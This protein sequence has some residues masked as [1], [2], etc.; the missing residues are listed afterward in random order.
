M[1]KTSQAHFSTS[2]PGWASSSLRQLLASPAVRAGILSAAAISAAQG[3]D[4]TWGITGSGSWATSANWA[5]VGTPSGTDPIAVG[6]TAA[7]TITLDT[8]KA[9]PSLSVTNTGTTAITAASGGPLG[10][11]LGAGGFTVATG[12]GLVTIGST[13]AANNVNVVLGASQTWTSA[14][15]GSHLI[16]GSITGSGMNLTLSGNYDMRS[17]AGGTPLINI[18]TGI[19]TLT[20]GGFEIGTG[21]NT[22]GGFILKGGNV[23]ARNAGN[24]GTTGPITLGDSAANTT[25]VAL[26]LA[27]ATW[28]RPVVLASGT[29]GTMFIDNLG[30]TATPTFT[31]GITGTNNF[32]IQSTIGS[33]S[34]SVTVSTGAIDFTGALTLRNQGTG[35]VATAAGTVTMNSAITD[36]VTNVTMTDVTTGTKGIQKIVLGNAA[37]AWSGTTTVSA[38]TRV[39]LGASE[40]IPHG[41]GKGNVVVNGNLILRTA[42]GDSTETINGLSGSSTGSITR[43]GA[44]GTS[45]LVVGGNDGGGTFAGNITDGSGKV[46]LTKIGTGTLV[47]SGMNTYTGL[48]TLSGGT[49][50]LDFP[51]LI[52]DAGNIVLE[53]GTTLNLT[54]GDV[55]TV[56]SLRFGTEPQARGKWGRIGSIAALGANF[57]SAQI[58]GDGLLD[59]TNTF[60]DSYWDGSGTSWASAASWSISPTNAAS[61]PGA[62]PGINNP[63]FFGSNGLTA[64]QVIA[65]NGDQATTGMSFTSPVAFSFTGGNANHVLTVTTGGISMDAVSTGVTIGSATAGQEVDLLLSGSQTWNNQSTGG[66]LVAS[67]DVDLGGGTLTVTGGGDTFIDGVVGGT[68]GITKTGAGVLGLYGANSFSGAVSLQ[69]GSIQ[70]GNA[71]GLGSTAGGTTVGGGTTLDLNGL[72]VGAEPITLGVSTAGNLVNNNPGAAAS[73]SGDI[74]INANSNAGGAGDLTLSGLISQTAGAK[75]LAKTGVGKLTITNAN[76]YTGTTT[77]ANNTG[78]VAI[79]NAAALGTGTVAITRGGT[80]TGTLELS[81]DITVANVFTFASATGFSAAGSSAQVRN[82][83]GN[84]TLT[85]TLT[86]TAT[87]GNGINLESN[88]GLL[89]VTNTIT[90]TVADSTRQLGLSGT[91]AGLVSGNIIDTG[92]NKFTVIKSGTGTW[93]LSGTNTYSGGTNVNA[94]VLVLTKNGGLADTASVNVATDGVLQLDFAGSDTVGTLILDGV[95]QGP[96]TYGAGNSGG[97]LTGTGTIT[98]VGS[99]PFTPWI[100]SFTF[101][102]GA[103]KSK[104][105]DPDGDGLSNLQE[106]AFDGNPSSGAASG[107]IVTKVDADHLTLT[108]PVRTGAVFTGTGP[109]T[110]AAIGDVIYRIDGSANLSGFTAGVEETTA[111]TAGLPALSSGW[112]YRTFRLTA[113]VSAARKGFL[114]ADASDAP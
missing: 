22:M 53:A 43:T 113:A 99:D 90:S 64:D 17:H 63:T 34:G 30:A 67:N 16:R 112:T 47:L 36:K 55:E 32:M 28:A 66:D 25:P 58:T 13:T 92:V 38:N 114:R 33:G 50:Q 62:E 45:T 31:G 2:S 10:L 71:G 49:L 23:F 103:D 44:S 51:D 101:A 14:I 26:R 89:T 107:K 80:S 105:G 86:L 83:S 48:T 7:T 42:T 4:Y 12:S 79:T 96:G 56:N 69:G 52:A 19:I 60:V 84:N 3:V 111:L 24:F 68:G 11:T 91:A 41:A 59:V 29:T 82:V 75:N 65:L 87:G 95:T 54:H 40:V 102:V 81:N 46:A 37:N 18:G 104:T 20:S 8:A 74:N 76:L 61:N 57:E 5:P 88:G 39:E 109:L 106:F 85:G 77:I 15:G 6:G 70:L 93:T 110:S 72:A 98:V 94:G 9:A 73:L 97:R 78:T 108:L 100:D 27:T 35:S 1:K 21:V